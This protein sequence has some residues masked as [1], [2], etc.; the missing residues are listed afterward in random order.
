MNT[1]YAFGEN[2]DE[3]YAARFFRGYVGFCGYI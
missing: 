3:L 1:Y 2:C